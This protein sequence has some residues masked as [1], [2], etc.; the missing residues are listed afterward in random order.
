[1]MR[2]A[3]G[4]ERDA[5]KSDCSIRTFS[6]TLPVEPPM[7]WNR[8]LQIRIHITRTAADVARRCG[9]A[10]SLALLLGAACIPQQPVPIETEDAG[11]G[12]S[13]SGSGGS[14]PSGSGGT[15][16][17]PGSG[18]RGPVGSGGA[19]GAAG[20]GGGMGGMTAGTGGRGGGG[21]AAAGTGGRGGAGGG[22]GV[23]G[24]GGRGG[25]GGSA[26]GTGGATGP[27]SCTNNRRDGSETGIDCGGSCPA[28]PN[29][30]INSPNR[31]NNAQSGCQGGPGYMCVRSMVLSPEMK[32]AASEDWGNAADPP[33]VYGTVGHDPDTGGIDAS[34]NTCCQCYQ[35]VFESPIGATGLPIPKPMI[36]QAFNTAA[37]GGKKFDI[38][39]AVGGYG[40]NNG[41]VGGASPMYDAFPDLGGDYTGGIRASRY[42]Q[43]SGM[44]GWNASTIGSAMCQD[45]IRGECQMIRASAS[46]VNQSTSQAS[47]IET[48]QVD[49]H[50]HI[51]W[52]VRAKRIEC[53][54][55][56]TRV[57]GCKLNNQGLPQADPNAQNAST[58]DSSFRT[59]YQTTTMQDCC[60]P[61]CAWPNNVANADPAWSI[62]YTC[63]R[64]GTPATQ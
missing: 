25:A 50:Y 24:T 26:A 12:S 62:F 35:L 5:V 33:F 61:T 52:N 59:G 14:P 7:I 29:Y 55:N 49:S 48:N 60:R 54:V 42:G 19:G 23:A 18:G 31:M 37:G 4:G 21:G 34:S 2:A 36:V 13:D 45:F 22:G 53:P 16:P 38:Y 47:C 28:C 27:G 20:S 11:S 39:M 30:K 3:R 57:T 64:A 58:A 40:A 46:P 43:C 51:N 1:M 10:A 8:T 9:H 32:Q 63:N 41:C 15:G 6:A 17:D 44:M 56:L